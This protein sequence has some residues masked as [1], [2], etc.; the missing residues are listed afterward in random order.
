MPVAQA[1]VLNEKGTE[2]DPAGADF[3]F[4]SRPA[5]LPPRAMLGVMLKD[6]ENGV[7]VVNVA[8]HGRARE[9]GLKKGDMIVAIDHETLETVEDLKIIMLYKKRGD[10]VL[11]R[12][13][14]SRAL[15]PDKDLEI[16]VTL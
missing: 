13:K 4:F 15:L 7:K 14:R 1:V 16:S 3:L 9:S 10:T 12:I 6:H 2:V 5:R 8:P 11:I